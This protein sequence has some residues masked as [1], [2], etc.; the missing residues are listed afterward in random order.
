MWRF[1]AWIKQK[2]LREAYDDS[3]KVVYSDGR[4]GLLYPSLAQPHEGNGETFAFFNRF[5]LS[6]KGSYKSF[7]VANLLSQ[8]GVTPLFYYHAL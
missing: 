5:Y 1:V 6:I 2:Q 3:F 8:I 4:R 7:Q